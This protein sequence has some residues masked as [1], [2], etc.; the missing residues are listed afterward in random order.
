MVNTNFEIAGRH[1]SFA[2]LRRLLNMLLTNFF[3]VTS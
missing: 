3:G 2:I 1:Y